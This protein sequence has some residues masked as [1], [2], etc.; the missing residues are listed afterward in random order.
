M[1]VGVVTDDGRTVSAHFGMATQ[2]LVFQIEDGEIKGRETRPKASHSHSDRE[3]ADAGS[4]RQEEGEH[5]GHGEMLSNVR[6]CEALIARGMGRPMY[7]SIL[8]LGI[9]PCVTDIAS[10][11]EAVGAYIKG[12]LDN[13]ATR[14]H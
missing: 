2:Y 7:E 14:L 3:Q 13:Q 10:A 11:E 1:K 8:R 6:D 9:K 12:S 4:V 5:H